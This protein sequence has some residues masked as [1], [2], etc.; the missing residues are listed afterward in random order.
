MLFRG[1]LSI[2]SGGKTIRRAVTTSILSMYID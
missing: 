1:V 2:P